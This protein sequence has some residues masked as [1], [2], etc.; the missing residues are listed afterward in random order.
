[1]TF[2]KLDDSTTRVMLQIGTEPTGVVEKAADAVGVTNLA[3]K[4]DL[5]NFKQFIEANCIATGG[6]R[7]EISQN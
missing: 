2:H 1:V 6:Y 3:A 5:E 4:R 7:G